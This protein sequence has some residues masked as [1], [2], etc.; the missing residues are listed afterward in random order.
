MRKKRGDISKERLF[1]WYERDH[2]FFDLIADVLI[3]AFTIYTTWVSLQQD[4]MDWVKVIPFFV[5][6][7]FVLIYKIYVIY[8]IVKFSFNII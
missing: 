1:K 2:P 5:I 3:L 8:I 4:S 7:L 6:A